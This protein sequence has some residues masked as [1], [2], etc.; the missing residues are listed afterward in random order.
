MPKD[1]YKL[2]NK[3][4]LLVDQGNTRV[5]FAQF[6]CRIYAKSESYEPS[7]ALID[8]EQAAQSNA[9]A[10]VFLASV[11]KTDYPQWQS[12]KNNFKPK[13]ISEVHSAEQKYG[14]VNAYREY[15]RLGVDRWLAMLGAYQKSLSACLVVDIGTALT[16]DVINKQGLHQGGYI[17][18]SVNWSVENFVSRTAKIEVKEIN[19]I[20]CEL[21]QSTES[22][23]FNGLYH[24]HISLIKNE[25][26]K[27]K[28]ADPTAQLWLTGGEKEFYQK[29]LAQQQIKVQLSETLIF[30]GLARYAYDKALNTPK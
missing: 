12:V 20:A 13:Q 15:G 4:V 29:L 7:I 2:F 1:K 25:F 8:Y 23:L 24:S 28:H 16:I 17:L 19:D 22:C 10:H 5:K 11:R 27:L 18:P 9:F 30:E 26:I 14:L 3:P 21:G 6:D